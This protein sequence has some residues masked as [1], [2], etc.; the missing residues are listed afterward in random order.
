VV[1]LLSPESGFC[2]GSTLTLDGGQNAGRLRVLSVPTEA[3]TG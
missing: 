3:G 2:T 1:F